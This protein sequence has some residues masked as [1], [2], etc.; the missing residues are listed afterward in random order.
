MRFKDVPGNFKGLHRLSCE[1]KRVSNG[2][3]DVSGFKGFRSF[4]VESF[5]E[6]PE[7]SKGPS[8]A[9]R[10]RKFHRICLT[11]E[12]Y[13]AAPVHNHSGSQVTPEQAE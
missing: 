7:G 1:F 8:Q 3:Q 13:R 11:T 9:F 12:T 4:L 10:F 5:L 6:H 2:F